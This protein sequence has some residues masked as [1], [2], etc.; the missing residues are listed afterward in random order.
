MT[1]D[2]YQLVEVAEGANSIKAVAGKAHSC[3]ALLYLAFPNRMI[4]PTGE[5]LFKPQAISMTLKRATLITTT[6][7]GRYLAEYHR[8]CTLLERLLRGKTRISDQEITL[9]F[10][11]EAALLFHAQDAVTAKVAQALT[12]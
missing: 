10:E 8:Y 5:I 9:L 3:A 11:S 6:D 1:P 4:E 12:S 2:F 7:V